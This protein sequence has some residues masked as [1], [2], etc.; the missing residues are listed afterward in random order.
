ML[1]TKIR[2]ALGNKQGSDDMIKCIQC[3]LMED[4]PGFKLALE[5]LLFALSAKQPLLKDI[6]TPQM[7]DL[8]WQIININKQFN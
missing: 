4:M 1:N 5:D 2:K 7:I 3:I 8:I 6:A